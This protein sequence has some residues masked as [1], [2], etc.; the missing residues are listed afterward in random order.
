MIAFTF[1]GQPAAYGSGN[2][3]K[4]RKSA[5]QHAIQTSFL[6]AHPASVRLIGDLYGIVLYFTK[7]RNDFVD[8]DADNISKPVWDSLTGYAY[9][10]DRQIR[11]RASGVIDLGLVSLTELELEPLPTAI[12]TELENFVL[13]DGLRHLLY[14]HVGALQPHHY[15]FHL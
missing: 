1:A 7:R 12:L 2:Y 5:Y 4:T 11:W 3:R 10:D 15:R 8:P 6:A 14:V 9:D 13:A